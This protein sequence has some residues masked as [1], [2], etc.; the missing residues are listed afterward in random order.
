MFL[1]HIGFSLELIA[2]IAGSALY[3]WGIRNKG[4]GTSFARIIGF[5]V[6]ILAIISIV[7]SSYFNMKFWREFNANGPM[8]MHNLQMQKAEEK[9][10]EKQAEAEKHT[11]K[12]AEKNK[13]H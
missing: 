6:V 11:E 10:E 9:A 5:L 3:I 1:F 2:L 4:E 12:H 7:C 13:K 8:S